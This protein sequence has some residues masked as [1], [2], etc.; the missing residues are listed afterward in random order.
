M[1]TCR[2]PATAG[3]ALELAGPTGCEGE[4]VHLD[5]GTAFAYGLVALTTAFLAAP[6]RDVPRHSVRATPIRSERVEDP[7]FA[8]PPV[9]A[10]PPRT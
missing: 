8:I 10:H 2:E 3:G 1:L 4:R 5:G 7:A 9:G 6:L